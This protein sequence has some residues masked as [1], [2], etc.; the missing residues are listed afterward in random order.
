MAELRFEPGMSDSKADDISMGARCQEGNALEWK[1]LLP[2][3][4]YLLSLP[5][6]PLPCAR[7]SA[8][9]LVWPFS[10]FTLLI[11]SSVCGARVPTSFATVGDANSTVTL[12]LSHFTEEYSELKGVETLIQDLAR[13]VHGHPAF[14][15][16]FSPAPDQS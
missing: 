5:R 1:T 13:F 15:S 9:S 2:G 14:C 10:V 8:P 4:E 12:L 11:V 7:Q 6:P 3:S 16:C